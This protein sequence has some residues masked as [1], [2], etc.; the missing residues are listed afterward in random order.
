MVLICFPTLVP[1]LRRLSG[2]WIPSREGI[3]P[4]FH[5]KTTIPL[6]LPLKFQGHFTLHFALICGQKLFWRKNL[7]LVISWGLEWIKLQV[8]FWNQDVIQTQENTHTQTLKLGMATYTWDTSTGETKAGL[9]QIPGELGLSHEFQVRLNN[10]LSSFLKNNMN[11]QKSLDYGL[12]VRSWRMH[13]G[14]RSVHRWQS[15]HCHEVWQLSPAA[16]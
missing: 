13:D 4:R 15:T 11:K 2:P 9:R 14:L 12:G 1:E 8:I 6:W 10:S 16:I 7:K 3:W 5:F